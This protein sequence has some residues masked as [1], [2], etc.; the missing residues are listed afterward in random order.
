MA[1]TNSGDRR[2]MSAAAT[3]AGAAVAAVML[4]GCTSAPSP[5]GPSQAAAPGAAATPAPSPATPSA[6]AAPL[7][8][9]PSPS[10]VMPSPQGPTDVTQD[11]AALHVLPFAT[12]PADPVQAEAGVDYA[13]P[14]AVAAGYLRQRLTY[15]FDNPAGYRSAVTAPAF[16]TPAFAARSEPDSAALT[17]LETAQ[18]TST[19]EVGDAELAHEAPHT[20]TTAYVEVA[21]TTTVT[22][23]G[24]GGTTAATWTLRLVQAPVGQWR[25]DG[26]LSTG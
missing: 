3:R 4:A 24:G 11:A 13:N 20:A 22:Y 2:I 9:A 17:R 6:P 5:A 15:R 23:R 14:L 16:T 18:E 8:T 10:T 21:C 1:G 7:T 12:G 19:V 25:V 26:V